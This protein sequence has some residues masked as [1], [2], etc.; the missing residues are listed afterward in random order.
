MTLKE[1]NEI[2]DKKKHMKKSK[3]KLTR[4]DKK[5][6][7]ECRKKKL[8]F[9]T[10]DK[11]CHEP[12]SAGPC[13][14]NKWFVAVKGQLQGACRTNQC[15][16]DETPIMFNKTCSELYGSCPKFSRLYL[17]KRGLGFCDCDEGYSYDIEAGTCF[18]EHTQGPCTDE[19]TWLRRRTPKNHKTGHKVFGKCKLN[20]CE[21]GQIEWKNKKCYK[22]EKRAMF[23]MCVEN[24]NGEMVVEDDVLTCKMVLEGRAV[25]L[26]V[27]RSCRRGRAWSPYR[28]RCVRVYSRG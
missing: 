16:N 9:S 2:F 23:D 19:Q 4:R 10:I 22:V 20:K 12:T 5:S 6:A 14:N 7:R 11:K 25:S 26:G 18:K 17:N 21:E 3:G 1:I 8:L 24:E 28:K 15:T 13:K 27:S